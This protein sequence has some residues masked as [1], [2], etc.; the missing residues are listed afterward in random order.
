LVVT[1]PELDGLPLGDV[2]SNGSAQHLPG[3]DIDKSGTIYWIGPDNQLHGYPSL[4][5]YNSWHIANDFSK[6]A[7]ANAADMSLPIGSLGS[8][9]VLQ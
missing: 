5:V 2:L 3:S 6:V 4:A 8:A 7:P 9:R 1:A